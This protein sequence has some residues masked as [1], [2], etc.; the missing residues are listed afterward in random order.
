MF[1]HS[2]FQAIGIPGDKSP[3]SNNGHVTT[4]SGILTTNQKSAAGTTQ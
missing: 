3:T 2:F 4:G 1:S